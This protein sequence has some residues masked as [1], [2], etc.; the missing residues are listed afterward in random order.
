MNGNFYVSIKLM[1][2]SWVFFVYFRICYPNEIKFNA[3]MGIYD[4]S[5]PAIPIITVADGNYRV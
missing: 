2:C 1:N 5:L 3:L 4:I